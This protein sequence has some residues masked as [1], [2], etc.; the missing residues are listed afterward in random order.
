MA[1]GFNVKC[2][3]CGLAAENLV[4]GELRANLWRLIE[5]SVRYCSRCDS[6]ATAVTLKSASKLRHIAGS[7]HSVGVTLGLS[8]VAENLAHTKNARCAVGHSMR[9][10]IRVP[11]S[12]PVP[13]PRC[14][15]KQ[16]RFEQSGLCVD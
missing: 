14:D 15:E 5:S 9:G 1:L 6:L 13:C 11:E 16:L 8:A 12:G 10:S 2:T 3:A 4:V 7:A